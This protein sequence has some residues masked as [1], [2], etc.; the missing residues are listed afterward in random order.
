[1]RDTCGRSRRGLAVPLLTVLIFV[2]CSPATE[3]RRPQWVGPSG[4]DSRGPVVGAVGRL[5]LAFEPNT[6]Q[7]PAEVRYVGRGTRYRLWLTATEARFAAPSSG[8][9]DPATV[10]VRLVGGAPAPRIAAEDALPGTVNYFVG[11][12]PAR[13]RR[14]VPTF[15]RVVYRGVYPG[16]DLVFHGTQRDAEFD[17]V[18]APGADPRAIA[19]ELDGATAVTLDEGDVVAHTGGAVL[20]LR[21]PAL[22]QEREGRRE[23]VPGRFALHGRRVAF[24]VGTYDRA[25]PLVIDPVVSY[26]TYLGGGGGESGRGVGVDAAGSM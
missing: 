14:G 15:R 6:G 11:R 8:G 22:Y 7:A 3:P 23:P 12:D 5:P 9:A 24:E 16:I 20:R 2:A 17:F 10:R 18:L 21:Q 19:V 13:W 25:R 4:S 1:M 26:S